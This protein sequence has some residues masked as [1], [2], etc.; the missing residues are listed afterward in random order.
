LVDCVKVID[1]PAETDGKILKT[2]MNADLDEAIG[3]VGMPGTSRDYILYEPESYEKGVENYWY[4]RMQVC[5]FLA[6]NIE[7]ENLGVVA[8]YVF[9]SVKNANA[10]PA[11]DIDLLIHFRGDEMQRKKLAV[12]LDGWSICL[13]HFNYLKTGY[14]TGGLLDVHI[15]T[16]ED[17]EN[18]TSFAV[19]IDAVTDTARKLDMRK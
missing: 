12:W 18:K 3:Y 11:S 4:W 1:I 8:L 10:G 15:I 14:K 5:E 7:A 17:I 2:F 13:D 6:Q 16:D 19:K 9:G